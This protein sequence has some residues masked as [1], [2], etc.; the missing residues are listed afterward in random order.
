MGTTT[1]AMLKISATPEALKSFE[2]LKLKHTVAYLVFH[3]CKK[4]ENNKKKNAEQAIKVEKQV[5][6]ADDDYL[7][8]FIEAV[9]GAGACRYGVVDWNNKLLF[10]AWTPDTAN[11]KD[12]MV[13]ASIREAFIE[14]LVGIQKKIQ[15]TD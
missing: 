12:K 8:A 5:L 2:T 13:Y 6:K 7:D 10:V 15:A 1:S 14:S 9:K 4:D 3:V 11:G